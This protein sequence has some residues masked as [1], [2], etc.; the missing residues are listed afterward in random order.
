MTLLEDYDSG[1][2]TPLDLQKWGSIPDHSIEFPL[3]LDPGFKLGAFFTSDATPL[4]MLIDAR[5]MQVIDATMGYSSDY[6]Q[7]VDE[8]LSTL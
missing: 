5:T 4:N 8:H 7:R 1:P 2:A 6:W 3:V